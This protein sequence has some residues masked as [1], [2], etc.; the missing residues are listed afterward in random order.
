MAKEDVFD[1]LGTRDQIPKVFCFIKLD[2]IHI[3]DTNVKRW[4]VHKNV[5]ILRDVF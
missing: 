4:V 2:P 5:H 3:C 1:I